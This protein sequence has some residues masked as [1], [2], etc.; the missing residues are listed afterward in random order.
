MRNSTNTT[1]KRVVWQQGMLMAPQHFQQQDR[2][3]ES[4]VAARVDALSPNPWGVMQ[5]EFDEAALRAGELRLRRFTGVMP[6]GLALEIGGDGSVPPASRPIRDHFPS[7][8]AAVSVFL[9]VPREQEGPG[10][11]IA[12]GHAKGNT[13]ARYQRATQQVANL[14]E[15]EK[16]VNKPVD[17][18]VPRPLLV[19]ADERRDERDFDVMPIAEIERDTSGNYHL[20][21]SYIPPVARVGASPV[22]MT[23]IEDISSSIILRQRE[24]AESRRQSTSHSAEFLERDITQYL[25]LHALNSSIP[26]LQHIVTNKSLSAHQTYL[27]LIQLAGAMTTFSSR[28]DPS[29]FPVYDYK[30]LRATFVPL[31]NTVRELLGAFGVREC[32]DVPLKYRGEGYYAWFGDI[33]SDALRSCTQFVLSVEGGSVSGAQARVVTESAPAQVP[34]KAYIAEV[35]QMSRLIGVMGNDRGVPLV[36]IASPPPGIPRRANRSYFKLDTSNKHWQRILEKGV[37]AIYMERPFDRDHVQL[38]LSAVP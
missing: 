24:M 15:S 29:T 23:A 7:D 11:Y 1:A 32:V 34:A 14:A 26:V 3:F 6:D 9:A 8:Q 38:T 31:M 35:E 2:Y 10:N 17:L 12:E 27:L 37:I 5:L 36:H 16:K 25:A 19:F 20:S 13:R 28:I 21:R 22:L 18:A 33:R 4:L 30:D